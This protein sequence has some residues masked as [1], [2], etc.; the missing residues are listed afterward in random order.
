[1]EA[2]DA[3][4]M[5]SSAIAPKRMWALSAHGAVNSSPS[6]FVMSRASSRWI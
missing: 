5:A 1:M 6:M 3:F 4:S 2:S